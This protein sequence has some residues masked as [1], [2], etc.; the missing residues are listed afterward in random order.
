MNKQDILNICKELHKKNIK[1][2]QESKRLKQKFGEM[3]TNY[4]ISKNISGNVFT[5]YDSD[6]FYIP[7]S[8]IIDDEIPIIKCTRIKLFEWSCYN[9]NSFQMDEFKE[10]LI[11][12]DDEDHLR[13]IIDKMLNR[14]ILGINKLKNDIIKELKEVK[15]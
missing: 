13:R 5:N 11:E 12:I 1:Y 15:K 2:K 3:N 8:I 10:E 6:E 14:Y 7:K 9:N 4:H